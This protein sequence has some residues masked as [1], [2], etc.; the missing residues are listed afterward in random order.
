MNR[1]IRMRNGA[2][3]PDQFPKRVL[4]G[5]HIVQVRPV[6]YHLLDPFR[7]KIMRKPHS[8]SMTIS[9][10]LEHKITNLPKTKTTM[11]TRI[12]QQ[13][14]ALSIMHVPSRPR[15]VMMNRRPP[16]LPIQ[17]KLER[18]Q[19]IIQIQMHN[20]GRPVTPPQQIDGMTTRDLIDIRHDQQIIV[21]NTR[22]PQKMIQPHPLVRLFDKRVLAFLEPAT[23]RPVSQPRLD[24]VKLI[25]IHP[26]I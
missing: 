3:L 22:D 2:H 6:T 15:S 10:H 13:I 12:R 24:K 20:R 21:F 11:P 25:A 17:I 1:R 16:T 19:I 8:I 18:V 5:K 26:E 7:V 14:I 4:L 9:F 23:D